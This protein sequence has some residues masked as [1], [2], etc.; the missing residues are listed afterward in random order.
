MQVCTVVSGNT[1][2]I[3]SGNPVKP[4]TTL[5]ERTVT[6]LK[7]WLD[8]R[9]RIDGP[10]FLNARGRRLTRSGIAYILRN[11][12]E[13]AELSPRHARRV[14][15]HGIRHTTAMHL[16]QAGVDITTIAAWLGHSQ[17]TTTHGYIE[18]DLRMKQKAI[19]ATAAIPEMAQG[20]YPEGQLLAWLAA[21]GK[22][23]RYVHSPP[24]T[25]VN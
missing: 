3:V 25:T 8:E 6:A 20:E 24:P 15:P 13:R 1:V 18:I 10:L 23:P 14:T 9:G 16:L 5:W 22:P 4:S 12:A 2:L 19:A 17:L 21:L 7:Q 11:L